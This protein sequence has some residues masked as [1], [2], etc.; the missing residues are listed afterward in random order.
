VPFAS[1]GSGVRVPLAQAPLAPP[2]KT[3][4][5]RSPVMPACHWA[6]HSASQ[7]LRASLL[8]LRRSSS[9]AHCWNSH[10]ASA[11]GCF[12]LWM[13]GSALGAAPTAS[14][15]GSTTRRAWSRW[16]TSVTGV[17]STAPDNVVRSVLAY[18]LSLPKRPLASIKAAPLRGAAAYGRSGPVEPGQRAS[19][20]G[21]GGC[22]LSSSRCCLL[23][24]GPNDLTA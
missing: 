2:R 14:S 23:L 24:S 16:W 8:Q 7:V 6:C 11:S 5:S 1:R 4:S 19:P 18:A 10:I 22:L 13:T 17:M 12:R 9:P 20:D 21:A 3:P 15:T